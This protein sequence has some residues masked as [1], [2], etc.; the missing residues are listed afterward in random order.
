MDKKSLTIIILVAV[1]AGLAGY[2]FRSGND[3]TAGGYNDLVTF[4]DGNVASSSNS[5][6][7]T[8]S[9]QLLNRNAGAIY[10][11]C[12]NMTGVPVF[13]SLSDGASKQWGIGLK[14][15]ESYNF[16]EGSSL[17]TGPVHAITLGGNARVSCTE[18]TVR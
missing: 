9:V 3:L 16:R 5:A 15:S 4:H 13:L 8:T 11:Y 14:S 7:S 12:E 17:Y 18:G 6:V 1:I 10:R 2:S